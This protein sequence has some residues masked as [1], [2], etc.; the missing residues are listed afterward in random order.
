MRI[1]VAMM[2]NPIHLYRNDFLVSTICLIAISGL[3]PQHHEWFAAIVT[4]RSAFYF[5][6]Q[7][8]IVG[9]IW[10]QC[11]AMYMHRWMNRSR[12]GRQCKGVAGILVV[13]AFLHALL[14]QAE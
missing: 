3:V 8:H 6:K 10:M 13:L 14:W 2:H 12:R 11:Q 7:C 1:L 9:F 5:F 4:I